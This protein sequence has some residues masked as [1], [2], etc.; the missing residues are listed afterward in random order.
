L[1]IEREVEGRFPSSAKVKRINKNPGWQ[2]RTERTKK[3]RP[4][5]KKKKSCHTLGRGGRG[6]LP[7]PS[8]GVDKR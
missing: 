5:V 2:N 8:T 7:A 6:G 4:L 3:G 1:K